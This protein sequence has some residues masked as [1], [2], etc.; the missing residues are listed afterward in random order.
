MSAENNLD[1][2]EL[3]ILLTVEKS[4]DDGCSIPLLVQAVGLSETKVKYYL[5]KLTDDLEFLNWFGSMIQDV[6]DRY[7][8]TRK[9][10][11]FLVEGSYI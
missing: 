9:G 8:L 4:G 5:D 10:R 1:N 6:P 2:I 11:D 3:K 7:T